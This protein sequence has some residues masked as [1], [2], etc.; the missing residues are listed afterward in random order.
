MVHWILHTVKYLAFCLT[1]K[2]GC[3]EGLDYIHWVELGAALACPLYPSSIPRARLE[4]NWSKHEFSSK[5]LPRKVG[6]LVHL[7]HVP[8]AWPSGMRVI[9][10]Y[11]DPFTRLL[12]AFGDKILGHPCHADLACIRRQWML[13]I[14]PGL[15]ESL[16]ERFI[17]T[18]RHAPPHLLNEHFQPQIQSCLRHTPLNTTWS[19]LDQ[20]SVA[21]ITEALG[22]TNENTDALPI[23]A[24]GQKVQLPCY[25]L[26]AKVVGHLYQFLAPDYQQ[27]RELTGTVYQSE[28]TLIQAMSEG[29]HQVCISNRSV[30]RV[31]S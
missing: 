29:T 3:S 8:H 25:V 30:E 28:G 18:V 23:G 10:L 6:P 19:D 5:Y 15:P 11:R 17:D 2:I 24:Y 16:L 14:R 13:S 1:P 31:S 4:C 7:R 9:A 27:I 20:S 21:A 22:H 26:S 12:S